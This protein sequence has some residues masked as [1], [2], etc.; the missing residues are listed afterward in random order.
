MDHDRLHLIGFDYSIISAALLGVFVQ[1]L[2]TAAEAG[3][4]GLIVYDPLQAMRNWSWGL[5]MATGRMTGR[6]VMADGRKLS[7]AVYIREVTTMLQAMY[8]R[9]LMPDEGAPEATQLLPTIIELTHHVEEGLVNRCAKHLDWAAKLMCL[10]SG[11]HAWG[12]AAARL[13][14]HDFA[15]TDPDRGMLW[16]LWDEGLVDPLV[17]I[18]DARACLLEGP[19]ETRAWARGQLIRKFSE[20]ISSV[21]WDHVELYRRPDSWWPRLRI[22]MPHAESMNRQQFE[23]II[24]QAENVA[25][26]GSLLKRN[27]QGSAHQASTDVGNAHP[28]AV[29]VDDLEV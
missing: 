15:N 27:P 6:A 14:D 3:Y 23:P 9:G 25:H 12:S 2:L 26:L 21:N 1:S 8:R 11:N 5:D 4:C 24:E 18:D 16:R 7:L 13:A 28:L 19:A 17:S 22:D 10:L 29:P 20:K